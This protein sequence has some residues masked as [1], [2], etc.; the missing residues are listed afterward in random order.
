[1]KTITDKKMTATKN[2]GAKMTT[3]NK[4][5]TAMLFRAKNEFDDEDETFECEQCDALC[6]WRLAMI[7]NK[8]YC[9]DC[10]EAI[11]QR[12]DE[13]EYENNN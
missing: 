6:S 2:N 12:E 3:T 5:T 9:K 13:E 8:K 10:A 11:Q 7:D 1:M 4:R